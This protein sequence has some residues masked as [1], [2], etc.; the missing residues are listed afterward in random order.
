MWVERIII[1]DSVV[2]IEDKA[3]NSCH[4]LEYIF[5]PETVMEIGKSA[6]IWCDK[7]TIKTKL[8]SYAEKFAKENN[9]PIVAE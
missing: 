8:G 7:L 5:I 1:P 4:E 9:I 2:K 6:F 3:F